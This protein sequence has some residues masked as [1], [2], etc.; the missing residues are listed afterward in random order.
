MP[1]FCIQSGRGDLIACR[2]LRTAGIMPTILFLSV[3]DMAFLFSSRPGMS[4]DQVN[5]LF[6]FYFYY[7]VYTDHRYAAPCVPI[8]AGATHH[9]NFS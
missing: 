1:R 5:H 4:A 6:I 7:E 2:I 3:M 8:Y 9:E